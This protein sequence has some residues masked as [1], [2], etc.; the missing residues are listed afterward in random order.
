MATVIY[1]FITLNYAFDI[2]DPG[3]ILTS[4][5]KIRLLREQI[6]SPTEPLPLIN[7]RADHEL[8]LILEK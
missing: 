3:N 4:T 6:K 1:E 8:K 2:N 5:E 7:L